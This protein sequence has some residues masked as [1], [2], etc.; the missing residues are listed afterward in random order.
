MR[1]AVILCSV[2]FLLPALLTGA[3]GEVLYSDRIAAV[4]NGDVI[5]LSDIERFKN[6]IFRGLVS[7]L[8][9]GIVPEGKHPTEKELLQELIMVKLLEQDAKKK[10][11]T[12]PDERLQQA[13]AVMSQSRSGSDQR[14]VMELA[15]KGVNY[16]D[17]RR[18]MRRV[19][20]IGQLLS[21]EVRRKLTVTE[22]EMQEYY[23]EHKDTLEEDFRSIIAERIG[24]KG[25]IPEATM[26]EIPTHMDVL[27][28]GRLR[29]R[30]LTVKFPPNPDKKTQKKIIERARDI[31]EQILMGADFR[32]MA[33][34]YSEDPY[35]ESGGDLGYIDYRDMKKDLR[36]VVSRIET[37]R[38]SI[39][40]FMGDSLVMFQVA[41][42]KGRKKKKVRIPKRELQRIK[43]ELNAKLK[44][45]EELI[46]KYEQRRQEEIERLT[47]QFAAQSKDAENKNDDD[48]A[49]DD[50]GIL[51]PEELQEY[52]KVKNK[53]RIVLGQKKT[54]DRIQ[55]YMSDLKDKSIIDDERL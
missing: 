10:G 52:E 48:A 27:V 47:A 33:K 38:V 23:K 34:K 1:F 19:L 25:R 20:T 22:K 50:I 29:L 15:M 26:P 8:N 12:I 42:A 4:V 21:Q 28:G 40:L 39:P 2:V 44:Q 16:S 36:K 13:L 49:T 31:Y 11:I 24:G 45:R 5:L 41:D 7:D 51:S 53:V 55:Q 35:A 3:S 9:L 6:P 17:F 54:R 14:L 18:T 32:E 30:Q 46:K 43:K 37:G